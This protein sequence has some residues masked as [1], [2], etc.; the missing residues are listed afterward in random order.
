MVLSLHLASGVLSCS[1]NVRL[2][3]GVDV[4]K[5]M[6]DAYARPANL[7]QRFANDAAGIARTRRLGETPSP[8]TASSLNRPA[9]IVKAAV[10]APCWQ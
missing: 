10:G 1:T 2:L 5:D 4:S 6:L 8:Q 3:V 9:H 7:R